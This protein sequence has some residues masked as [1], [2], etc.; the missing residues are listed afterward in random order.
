MTGVTIAEGKYAFIR[1]V[2]DRYNNTLFNGASLPSTDPEKKSFSYDIFPASL[3]ENIITAKTFTPDKPADFSGGLVQI[4]TVEFPSKFTLNV[5]TSADY[6]T[7]TTG[8][9]FTSYSGG[10]KDLFRLLMMAQEQC[11]LTITDTK[12]ARGNYSLTEIN[13]IGKSFQNNWN[14]SLS[15]APINGNLKITLGDNYPLGGIY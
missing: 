3:I 6:R 9:D 10:S 1:G 7:N 13:D 12:V 14:T 11:H 8:K 4:S 15:N 2:G 5:S